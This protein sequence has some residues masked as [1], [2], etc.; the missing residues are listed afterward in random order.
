[1]KLSNSTNPKSQLKHKMMY[2]KLLCSL[3]LIIGTGI[4]NV[5][6]QQ[7]MTASG[8][9]ANSNSGSVSYSV[10]QTTYAKHRGP[11]HTISEGVQQPYNTVVVAG[12]EKTTINP[13]YNIY[14]NP[15]TDYLIL[16]ISNESLKNLSY[17]IFDINSMIISRKKITRNKETIDMSELAPSTYFLD[18]MENQTRIKTFKIIKN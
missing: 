4:T 14:P 7:A 3:L 8:G 17:T 9:N 2:K 13:E 16:S 10:G 11:I 18:I 15:V 6:A 5:Y 1:M 12:I